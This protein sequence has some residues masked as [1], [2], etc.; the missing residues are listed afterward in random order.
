MWLFGQ[1]QRE[2]LKKE[3]KHFIRTLGTILF[4]LYV[5]LLI[6]FLFFF[7]KYGRASASQGEYRYNLIPFMEIQR[8]WKYRDKL[9]KY[10]VHANL[11][12][13]V[14]GFLPW[15]FILPVIKDRMR[16]GFLVILSGFMLS[17]TVESIQLVTKT[18][19]FDVDDIILNT[20][21]AAF[22]YLLF[23]ICNHLRRKK[24]GKKI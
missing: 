16:S 17:F 24:Y 6:Y 4:I 10:A 12:G 3:T 2:I 18:G 22:G 8:F 20:L 21:G 11:L 5:F 7:E 9:G 19:C 1:K 14:I 13:N 23:V 15:G